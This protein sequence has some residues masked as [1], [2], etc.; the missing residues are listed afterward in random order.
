[1]KMSET[2][3]DDKINYDNNYEEIYFQNMVK[4]DYVSTDNIMSGK[5]IINFGEGSIGLS[6]KAL[7]LFR[8]FDSIFR[9]FAALLGGVEEQYPVLL[10]NKT[11]KDTGYLRTSPQYIHYVN[12]VKDDMEILADLWK[13]ERTEQFYDESVGVLSPSACFHVYENYR[14]NVLEQCKTVTLLQNVFRNEGRY[15]RSEYGRLRDYH[16]REIVFIGSE[17]YVK[18][19]L[20]I[21]MDK[22]SEFIRETGLT[23]EIKPASDSFIL[24]DMQKYKLLQ[25][26]NKVKYEVKLNYSRSMQLSAASFNFHGKTFT[27]P[28]NIKVKDEDETVTGCAGYGLERWVLAYLSQFEEK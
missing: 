5:N 1:M 11:L 2:K 21:L 9:G 3:S 28:F 16:V 6:G 14:N 25:L 15:N 8:Y 7:E 23:G 27:Y 24:P 10:D 22:T 13:S 12:P 19:S 18:K 20:K 4:R 26:K 17:D